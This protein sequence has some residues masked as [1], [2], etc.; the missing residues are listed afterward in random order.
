M[1]WRKAAEEHG[2]DTVF[3]VAPSSTD[4]RLA[5][6]TA[7]GSGFVYAAAVMGVTGTRAAVGNLAEDLV[8]RTRATTSLPV[9][10]G[11]GVSDADQAAEVAGF[12]DGVIVG[13]AF[14]KRLLE[15]DEP[16][17][18]P[19]RRPGARGRAGG[20]RPPQV[21]AGGTDRGPSGERVPLP[22]RPSGVSGGAPTPAG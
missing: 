3:V 17:G 13:S 4:H 15:A 1:E 8:A 5:E 20:G 21:A 7:A 9:C 16:A 14:V 22:G 6:V 12:A 2:L 10:V 18:L 11:L 19:G